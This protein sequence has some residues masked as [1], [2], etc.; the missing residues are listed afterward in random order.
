VLD[1][2]GRNLTLVRCD[3]PVSS[4]EDEG[5]RRDT[6]CM[7]VVTEPVQRAGAVEHVVVDVVPVPQ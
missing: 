4:W 2:Y 1:L 5:K 3:R 6:R 7:A